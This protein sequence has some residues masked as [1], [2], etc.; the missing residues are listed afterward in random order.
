MK[1]ILITG[2]TTVKEGD[3]LNLSCTVESFP[4]SVISWNKS[5]KEN[6]LLKDNLTDLQE[7]NGRGTFFILN[8]TAE[9]AGLYTCTV[10]YLNQT[11]TKVVNVTVICKYSYVVTI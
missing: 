9:D 4:P 10:K 6:N 5:G 11:L 2:E 7:V 1:K 8:M 3:S